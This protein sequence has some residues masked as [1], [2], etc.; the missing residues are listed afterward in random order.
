MLSSE[1]QGD[2]V[3]LCRSHPHAVSQHRLADHLR[4][5]SARRPR[6]PRLDSRFPATQA[7][8]QEF[9]GT[10]DRTDFGNQS[11][12]E[13]GMSELMEWQVALRD[14]GELT[15]QAVEHLLAR[16][17]SRGKR[18]IEGV[19]E[20]R[21]KQYLDFTVVVGHNDEYIVEGETCTCEDTR[22]NLDPEDPSARCWHRL[23]AEIADRIDAVDHHELW[24][25]DVG[26]LM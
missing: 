12:T 3:A 11:H 22:Y 7:R 6:L 17:G 13:M 1:W 2:V 8:D 10:I 24:Y 15:P 14:A 26:E 16:H 23:A 20:R 9:C 19:G 18:A 21:V 4:A 5:P 25:S